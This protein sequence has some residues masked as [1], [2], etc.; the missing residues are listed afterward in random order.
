MASA[1]ALAHAD[2]LLAKLEG[3]GYAGAFHAKVCSPAERYKCPPDGMAVFYNSR[4][5]TPVGEAQGER[6]RSRLPECL[7]A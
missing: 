3:L 4:R 6:A 2:E 5:F 1:R 7:V